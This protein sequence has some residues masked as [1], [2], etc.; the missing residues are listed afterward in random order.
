MLSLAF[1]LKPLPTF[2]PG[3]LNVVNKTFDSSD[4][5]SRDSSTSQTHSPETPPNSVLSVAYF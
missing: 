1:L 4:Q 2:A 3:F 5:K